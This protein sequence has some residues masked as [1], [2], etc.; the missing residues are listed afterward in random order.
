MNEIFVEVLFI[1]AERCS[2]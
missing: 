1:L 2:N